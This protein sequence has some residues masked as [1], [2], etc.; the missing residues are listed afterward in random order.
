[1]T[2][3]ELRRGAQEADERRVAALLGRDYVAF[4]A[5]LSDTLVYQ[6]ASG[7]IDSKASYLPQFHEGRVTFTASRLENV[8]T[9]VVGGAVI[10]QGVARNE[11]VVE[12]RPISAATRFFSVWGCENGRWLMAAWASAP[13]E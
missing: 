3:D 11:L 6:H 10:R 2:E 7:K 9:H 4:A 12:G 5:L 13:L 1:M 8:K